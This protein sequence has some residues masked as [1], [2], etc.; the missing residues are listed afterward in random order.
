MRRKVNSHRAFKGEFQNVQSLSTKTQSDELKSFEFEVV[1]VN[2]RGEEI[3][4]EPKETKYYTE[5]LGNSLKLD[6]LLIP[7]GSFRMG[8][9]EKKGTAPPKSSPQVKLK[10]FFLGKYPVTQKQ[11]RA[12]V[13]RPKV[14]VDLEPNPSYFK[15]D[16]R[17]V[18]GISWYDAVEFCQ[19]LSQAT[20][21][22]YRLPTETE[23]E[24]ACRAGTTT[25]FHF[26]ETITDALVN[27]DA[28]YTYAQEPTGKYR[29]KTTPVGSFPPNAFGLYD[30]HGLVWEWCEDDWRKNSQ[31]TTTEDIVL[32]LEASQVR[33][34]RGGSWDE[35]PGHCRS[36]FRELNYSVVRVN[37]IGFRILHEPLRV[38]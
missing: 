7:G 13:F 11:W 14:K 29:Q 1:S 17:P 36:A 21:K 3:S 23:W 19:R 28:S 26:G 8:S 35:V 5:D 12:M 9:L 37:F 10:S 18:E 33:V 24:Y 30:L 15:G 16:E 27:Y 2:E 34:I 31:G 6:M 20:G 32:R 22:K 4:R 38:P 25:P